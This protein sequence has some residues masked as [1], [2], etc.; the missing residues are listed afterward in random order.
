MI[1]ALE[2]AVIALGLTSLAG[3]GS[4]VWVVRRYKGAPAAPRTPQSGNG[5][6]QQAGSGT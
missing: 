1:A 3:I 2:T 6:G 4:T 5:Q